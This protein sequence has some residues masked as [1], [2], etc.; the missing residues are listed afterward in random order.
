M[1]GHNFT[2]DSIIYKYG[3]WILDTDTLKTEFIENPYGF[4][5]YKFEI[6]D[7]K[8]IKDLKKIKQN[9]VVSVVCSKDLY[10]DCKE[11]LD[12][13]TNIITHRLSTRHDIV[14]TTSSLDI[15]EIRGT[16]HIQRLIQFCHS[17]IENT[18][19]LEAELAEICK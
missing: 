19:I 18:A 13:N 6:Y 4:N 17:N 15:E 8:E 3:I 2:N 11:A 12:L 9:A 1:S 10:C 5:F 7:K 16:D 14:E